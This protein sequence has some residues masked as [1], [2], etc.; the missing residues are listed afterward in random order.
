MVLRPGDDFTLTDSLLEANGSSSAALF[1]QGTEAGEAQLRNDTIITFGPESIGVGLYVT[2]PAAT[3]MIHATNV[4]AD[5]ATD[6]NAGGT[7][8]ST[9]TI[10]FDYSNLDTMTGAVSAANSETAPPLFVDAAA[11]NYH[12]AFGSPTIDAGINDPAN[13]ETVLD[14]DPR[15]L[16]GSIGC[17]GPERPAITDIGAYERVP[18]APPCPAPVPAD[19]K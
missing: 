16:P 15:A 11:G 19:T 5:A 10:S 9:G 6:A 8:G 12:E 17:G 13:G 18:I 4:I 14:G 1:L 2:L 3:V 7:A